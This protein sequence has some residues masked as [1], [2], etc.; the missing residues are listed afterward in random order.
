MKG[1]V[2]I[3][4]SSL[5]FLLLVISF[6]AQSH[7]A[8]HFP[9]DHSLDQQPLESKLYYQVTADNLSIED[10]LLSPAQHHAFQL[11][12]Y[13]QRIQIKEHEAVWLF[14][15]L[16]Y[17]GKTEFN[18]LLHYNFPLVDHITFFQIDRQ[19]QRLRHHYHTGSDYP[20]SERLLAYP[21]FAFPIKFQPGEEIDVI[22][23]IQDAG[24][25]PLQLSLW[26]HEA[27]TASQSQLSL[28]EGIISGL[29][30]AIALY[31]LFLLVRR[32]QLHY[33]Y[34]AGFYISLTLVLATISGQGF[35]VLWPY[36]PEINSAILY[37]LSGITLFCLNQFTYLALSSFRQKPWHW[38]FYLNQG[39]SLLVLFSPLFA[40]G[41]LRVHVLIYCSLFVLISNC[42]ICFAHFIQGHVKARFFA[43]AWLCLL[44]C[45]CLLMLAELGQLQITPMLYKSLLAFFIVNMALTSFYFSSHNNGEYKTDTQSRSN[46]YSH[47]FT[48][49]HQLPGT[50]FIVSSQGKLISA[51]ERFCQ[52]L[53]AEFAFSEASSTAKPDLQWVFPEWL[54]LLSSSS[55]EGNQL[56]TEAR[57]QQGEMI[58][59]LVSMQ[60]LRD[61]LPGNYILGTIELAKNKQYPL[62]SMSLNEQ[63]RITHLANKDAFTHYLSLYFNRKIPS[64]GCLLQLDIVDF[65]RVNKQCGESVGNALLRQ[66]AGKL[67]QELPVGTL[68]SRLVGDQFIA[69]IEHKETQEAF[70][71]SYRILDVLRGFRF[72]WQEHIFTVHTNIGLVN[73]RGIELKVPKL[74]QQAHSACLLAKRKGPDRIH[75][76]HEPLTENLQPMPD[77]DHWH[78][79]IQHA[80]QHN[81]FILCTQNIHKRSNQ[82]SDCYEVLIRMR[83]TDGNLINAKNFYG[84]A[85][86]SGLVSELDRWVLEHYFSWLQ[87]HP[88]HLTSFKRCH[89]NISPASINDPNFGTYVLSQLQHYEIPANKVCFEVNE[90]IAIE[91]LTSTMSF[92]T[93]V[94]QAGCKVCLDNFGTGFSAFDFLQ[95]LPVNYIKI[96]GSIIKEIA[97]KKLSHAIA[98]SIID[99][100]HSQAIELIAAHV[101][102]EDVLAA[103]EALGIDYAQGIYLNKPQ[104]LT[105]TYPSA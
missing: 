10:F 83:G 89:I 74:M 73:A 67:K 104:L 55:L 21:G 61:P 95:H 82:S 38:L 79:L 25:V 19:N 101:E 9:F 69:F 44:M 90:Y 86:Q 65:K 71:L 2:L 7:Y 70:I 36:H 35:A 54:L 45:G 31:N 92:I 1:L 58:R 64:Y 15:R 46:A 91:F 76:F 51:N 88:E 100:A 33:L 68:L 98:K 59:V 12:E 16:H 39:F 14:I 8:Q 47:Y 29:L 23:K 63:D 53:T 103:I 81:Q 28:V 41:Q 24:L 80:L 78:K 62:T 56:D 85:K 48:A 18:A 99:V 26:Q 60:Q 102:S 4:R 40:N 30:F 105:E 50:H 72:I 96:D 94:Q 87:K 11:R 27:F 66:V 93:T 6:T 84:I 97:T 49:F 22:F 13:K 42:F 3:V 32:K 17:T 5:I 57:N 77:H 34:Q 43:L 20:F 52:L 75:L 37:I